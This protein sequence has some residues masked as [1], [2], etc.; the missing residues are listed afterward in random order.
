[1][2]NRLPI[3]LSAALSMSLLIAADSDAQITRIDLEVVESPALD[4]RSYGHVG[5]YEFLRGVVYGEA[6]PTDPRHS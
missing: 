5:Q 6:D 2:T 1:M 3:A 4:G